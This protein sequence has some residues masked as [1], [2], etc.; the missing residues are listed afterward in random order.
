MAQTKVSNLVNPEV[1]ADMISAELPSKIKFAPLA[2]VDTTLVGQPGN[3]IT[4][5][6]FAYIGDAED[7]AE[8][9]AMGTTVLTATT[10]QA[11]VKKIGKA[12]ELTEEAIES[13]YGDPVGEVNKQL[14]NA[15]AS[16][17]DADLVTA[18]GTATLVHDASDKV[19]SYNG[20]VEAIDK[21][22]EEDD[23]PKVLFIHPNQKSAIRK[24]PNFIN[25]VENAVLSGAIGEFAGCQVV[26]SNKVPLK[27]G[28]YTNFIVKKGALAIFLKKDVTIKTDEDILAGTT[29]IAAN[30]HYVAAL[31]DESKVV[32]ALFKA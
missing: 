24:D 17:V 23:E 14:M 11:T 9:V 26:A 15:I 31:K 28:V 22:G 4:I 25:K 21:F 7:V 19:I 12:V 32:K 13:G 29:V 27:S 16:K 3:T 1:M 6:R 5:P 2:E 30:Q 10:Q 20:I 18:L 8:G